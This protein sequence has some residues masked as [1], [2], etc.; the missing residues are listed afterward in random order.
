MSSQ[1]ISSTELIPLSVLADEGFRH[2]VVQ[3]RLLPQA[4]CAKLS[5]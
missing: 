3:L 5:L 4:P 1:A 2:S